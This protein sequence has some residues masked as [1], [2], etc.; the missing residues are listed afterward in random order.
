MQ[1]GILKKIEKV[2]NPKYK[3]C[4]I[5]H[6]MYKTAEEFALKILRGRNLKLKKLL[7]NFLN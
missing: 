6:Y 2:S 5:R 1:K 7:M 4:H 3:Y